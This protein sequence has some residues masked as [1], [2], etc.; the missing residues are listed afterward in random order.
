MRIVVTGANGF[1]GAPVVRA[2]LPD[3][4]ILAVDCLR[5]GPW[6]FDLSERHQLRLATLDLREGSRV[7]TLIRDFEPAAILHLAAMHFIPECE[8][9]PADAVSINVLATVNVLEACPPGCRLV[10]VSTAAVYA[11]LDAPHVE[12]SPLGPLDTY[13]WTKLHAEDYVRYFTGQRGLDSVIVRLFNVLGPGDTNPHV[14]PE[15]IRQL[16]LG[17][18]TLSLG[19]V[20]TRRDYIHVVDVAAGL[21]AVTL[22]QPPPTAGG[23]PI[24]VNLGTGRSYSVRELVEQ[25]SEIIG[26]DIG[27][28]VDRARLRTV[29]RPQLLA[30]TTRLRELFGW[31]PRWGIDA[32]LRSVWHGSTSGR[33][34]DRAS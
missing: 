32:A 20:D 8:R 30:D 31:T 17:R 15:I 6:Q 27:I 9:L 29:D 25:L 21:L 7:Q 34:T 23:R 1:V 18:R 19:N 24:V 4:E 33:E 11:P 28:S 10:H 3:H 14:V 26:H 13:G 5:S 12:S 16:Q 2:L 22:Q